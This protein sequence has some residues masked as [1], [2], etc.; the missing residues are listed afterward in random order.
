LPPQDQEIV[1]RIMTL[2]FHQIDLQNREDDGK[3]IVALKNQGIKF[4]TPG[5]PVQDQ[6]L[7]IAENASLEMINSGILPKDAGYRLDSLLKEFR[8]KGTP[9]A[10]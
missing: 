6:W 5:K 10:Q 3:A 2:A 8:A 4:I 9:G 1:T 7:K